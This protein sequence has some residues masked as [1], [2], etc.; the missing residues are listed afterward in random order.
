MLILALLI[1]LCRGGL[2]LRLWTIRRSG[3]GIRA[4]LLTILR[5]LAEPRVAAAA[6]PGGR[7]DCR[8]GLAGDPLAQ[9][10]PRSRFG[11]GL[12]RRPPLRACGLGR[13]SGRFTSG[14]PIF[15]WLCAGIGTLGRG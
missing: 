13:L 4:R 11:S 9:G 15:G 3:S 5:S 8:A 6:V 1:L 2:A 10:L 7:A 14:L 12:F